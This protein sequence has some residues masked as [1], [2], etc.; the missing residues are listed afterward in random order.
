[1]TNAFLIQFDRKELG[2]DWVR[3]IE[4][5][6]HGLPATIVVKRNC[7]LLDVKEKMENHGAVPI[8]TSFGPLIGKLFFIFD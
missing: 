7:K 2:W 4:L 1:M 8:G 5:A 6:S 3:D